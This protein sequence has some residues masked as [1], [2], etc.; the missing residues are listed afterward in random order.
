MIRF[1]R[2]RLEDM[3]AVYG[4]PSLRSLITVAP[5]GDKFAVVIEDDGRILGGATGYTEH[6]CAIIQAIHV[7]SGEGHALYKD[8][9]V[10]S[11]IHILELDG[12]TWLLTV[13]QDQVYDTIGF[14]RLSGDG[15]AALG[16]DRDAIGAVDGQ[17]YAIINLPEFFKRDPHSQKE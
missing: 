6:T 5:K 2:M 3:E 12:F 17:K 8:G 1:R 14:K 16:L 11:L 4:E 13:D 10:R 9:L 15:F 7:L